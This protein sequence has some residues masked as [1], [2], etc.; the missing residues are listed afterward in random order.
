[1]SSYTLFELNEYIRQ[2]FA[3]NLPDALWIKAEVHQSNLSRGHYYMDLVQKAEDKDDII[4]QSP[5]ILWYRDYKKLKQKIGK[6]L[7]LLL[8]PGLE[9][10][11]QA[12]V[13]FHERYGLKLIIEDIDPS[14]TL[15][16]LE[17]KKQQSIQELER[18]H[19]LQKN[20]KLPLP[21]VLQKVA[22][23]SSPE[24]AGF[25]DFIQQLKNNAYKY[26]FEPYLFPTA[27]QGIFVEKE[28]LNQLKK[29]KSWRHRFDA[30]IIIRGGGS[31]LDLSAFDALDLCIA[32]AQ[33]P[34]PILTGI[35]HDIDETVADMIAHTAL[36]TPTAVA[37][38]IIHR[39][40]HFEAEIEE[41]GLQIQTLAQQMLQKQ[42]LWL[43]RA[44]Q[45]IQYNSQLQ[46]NEA[47]QT[48][49]FIEKEV[50]KL[51]AHTLK[52][53]QQQLTYLEK[54]CQLLSPETAL[55]RG[56]SITTIN[57]KVLQSVEKVAV[58]DVLKTKLKDGIVKSTV[59]SSEV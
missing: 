18:L 19:L 51:V 43:D 11:F 48:L 57:G 44:Q 21:L 7:N 41:R 2:I 45:F 20:K 34:L 8:Q 27:V 36:K 26:H 54:M 53:E 12:K 13:D 47:K 1:M 50:P 23:L 22:V 55:Q 31:K 9:I 17:L 28:M 6:N 37:D 58:G 56:F 38:F 32:L 46:L 52:K 33:F 24:A 4:A 59:L 10:L 15:G 39:T 14:Y 40:L 16:K 49:H 35:G 42:H 30:V 25:Q 5:A 3:L 29:I